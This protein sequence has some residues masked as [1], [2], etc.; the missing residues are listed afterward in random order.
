MLVQMLERGCSEISFREAFVTGDSDDEGRELEEISIRLIANVGGAD[1]RA[2]VFCEI[3]CK[4][5]DFLIYS[6]IFDRETFRSWLLGKMMNIREAD[7][8]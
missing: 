2:R 5:F 7:A 4:R 1:C 3:G 8:Y 6:F